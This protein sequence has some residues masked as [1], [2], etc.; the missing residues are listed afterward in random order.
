MDGNANVTG[1]VGLRGG[2]EGEKWDGRVEGVVATVGIVNGGGDRFRGRVG[3]GA[4]VI[5][6]CQGKGLS[7]DTAGFAD[8]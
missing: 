2:G 5:D 6:C 7:G 1:R 3:V 8:D 4:V